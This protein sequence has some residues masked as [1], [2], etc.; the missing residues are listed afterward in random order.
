MT[1]KTRSYIWL[2]F[3]LLSLICVAD[4]AID[5]IRGDK[6]WWH[7]VTLIV[8]TAFCT[9]YYFCYRKKAQDGN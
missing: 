6:K 1:D 3:A 5:M 8:I 4:Q 2:A 9:K 7:L